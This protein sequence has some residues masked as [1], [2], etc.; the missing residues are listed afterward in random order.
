MCVLSFDVFN[1]C[2][3]SIKGINKLINKGVRLLLYAFYG[4][5]IVLLKK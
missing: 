2:S 1:G 5:S 4:C 3:S